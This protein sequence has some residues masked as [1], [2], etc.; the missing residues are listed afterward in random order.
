MVKKIIERAEAGLEWIDIKTDERIFPV[1]VSCPRCNRNLIDK[2]VYIDGYPS[3]LV[4]VSFGNRHGWLR[5]SR[6]YGS[7]SV[8]HEYEV[9]ID[10]IV[11]FFC[12]HCNAELTGISICTECGAPMVPMIVKGGGMVQICSRR[13]C[14]GHMLDLNGVNL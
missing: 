6:L 9:P 4:M 3:I 7:Y 12:P 5:L 1:D 2:T 8:E 10:A 14:K 11:H 13:G